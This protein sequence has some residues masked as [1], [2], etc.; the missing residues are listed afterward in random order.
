M[1]RYP[2]ESGGWFDRDSA[3]N[4]EEDSEWNG[5]NMVSTATRNQWCHESL[6]LTPKGAWILEA[7]SQ[8]QDSRTTYCRIST[9][10]AASWLIRSHHDIDG[11]GLDSEIEEAQA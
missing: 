6:Y 5:S 3:R 4:W 2:L 11:L 10:D 7:W 9:R 8:Y 1:T